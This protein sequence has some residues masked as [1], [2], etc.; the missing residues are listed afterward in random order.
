[1]TTL[2]LA[3]QSSSLQL[4]DQ[5]IGLL[6]DQLRT[7]GRL[8]NALVIFLSD[9]GEAMVGVEE[10]VIYKDREPG[11]AIH[12]HGTNIVSTWQNNVMFAVN[13]YVNG[14]SQSDKA[15]SDATASLLDVRHLV[16]HY[17]Q[18]GDIPIFAPKL[19]CLPVET[20]LRIFAAMDYE[21]MNYE[22]IL[23]EGLPFYEVDSKGR[24]VLNEARLKELIK[25]KD[26]GVW[27]GNKLTFKKS[28][29]PETTY[30]LLREGYQLREVDLDPI[31]IA[32]LE[33]HINQYR[34]IIEQLPDDKVNNTLN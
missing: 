26:F 12:G 2:N 1:M 7:A 5:Q 11:K 34:S 25:T 18:N 33:Q 19:S 24:M 30:T 17:V 16:N 21:K 22:S 9:H 29:Q 20:G 13:L 3:R 15:Y 23:E 10:P 14:E 8:D 32:A 31:G 27:C 4:V 28:S 6:M